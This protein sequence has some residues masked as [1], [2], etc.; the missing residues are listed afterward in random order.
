[1][2][3][4]PSSSF[5]LLPCGGPIPCKQACRSPYFQSLLLG[6]FAESSTNQEKRS[7]QGKQIVHIRTWDE[8]LS[9]E[10]LEE[11]FEA[12]VN[13]IYSDDIQIRAQD[14]KFFFDASRFFGLPTLQKKCEEFYRQSI[15]PGGVCQILNFAEAHGERACVD[16]TNAQSFFGAPRERSK[17]YTLPFFP[18]PPLEQKQAT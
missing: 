12:V 3:D 4:P 18:P 8:D 15:D 9:P 17:A 16:R 14:A 10:R 13:F 11:T 7:E 1:M 6:D 2:P 5:H